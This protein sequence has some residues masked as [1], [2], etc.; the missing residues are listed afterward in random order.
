[1][2]KL[3]ESLRHFFGRDAAEQPWA[4]AVLHGGLSAASQHKLYYALIM[5]ASW[6]EKN[7]YPRSPEL[8]N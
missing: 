4:E 8:T 3:F 1:M 5:D 6:I 2:L 7:R